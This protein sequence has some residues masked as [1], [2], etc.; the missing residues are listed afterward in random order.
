MSNGVPH[1]IRKEISDKIRITV[2]P[3][4]TRVWDRLS[5]PLLVG[6]VMLTVFL[7]TKHIERDPKHRLPRPWSEQAE[8]PVNDLNQYKLPPAM[9]PGW[10]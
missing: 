4:A 9:Q 3:G 6:L 7:L 1:P 5:F 2:L 8:S 10:R